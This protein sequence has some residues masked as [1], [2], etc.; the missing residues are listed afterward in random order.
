MGRSGIGYL[1]IFRQA[2]VAVD[3]GEGALNDP[4]PCM[5]DE[6]DL[7]LNVADD[8]DPDGTGHAWA[9]IALI[10]IDQITSM[11]P[12]RANIAAG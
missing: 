8:L 6:P 4:A 5:H 12:Q 9:L 2:A 10:R 3:P 11:A 7:S 1:V